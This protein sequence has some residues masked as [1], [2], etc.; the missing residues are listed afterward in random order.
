MTTNDATPARPADAIAGA[1]SRFAKARRW[2]VEIALFAGVYFAV[3]SLQERNLLATHS[4]A[5]AFEL[6]T[7]DG[8]T[9]SLEALRGKRVALHFWATWC[10]VCR[11][12]FGALNA[13]Q[14]G[15]SPDEAVYAIVADSDDPEQV[16]RFVAEHHITY[17]VLLGTGEVLAAYRV[18]SFPTTY[19]VDREGRIGAHTVGMSTRFLIRAR[20]ALLG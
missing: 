8:R 11:R 9:V 16:R 14:Q 1:P 18:G 5:P 12:E 3:S 6:S 19:Y 13:V 7:L 4:P 2:A 17:P 15:L 20:M 10:G